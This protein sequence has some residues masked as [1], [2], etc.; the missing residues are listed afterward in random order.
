MEFWGKPLK[1]IPEEDTLVHISQASLGE[2]KNKKGETVPLYV[3]VG[4]QKLV[5]GTLLSE[6]IPQLNCDLVF[7]KE[8]ELSHNWGKG[9]DYFVGFKSPNIEYP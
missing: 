1:V 8:F 2:C 4:N 9:S 3:K 6:S 5:L 7:D